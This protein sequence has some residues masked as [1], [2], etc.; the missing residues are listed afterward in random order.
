MM[1]VVGAHGHVGCTLGQLRQLR[2]LCKT[3]WRAITD[4]VRPNEIMRDVRERV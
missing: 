3:S 4:A 2:V 1:N